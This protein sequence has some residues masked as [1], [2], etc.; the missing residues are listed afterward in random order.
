[1]V[2]ER[3]P[4]G[5]FRFPTDGKPTVS[6]VD[7][8]DLE[9][10]NVARPQTQTG[11]QEHDGPVAEAA[12]AITGSNRALDIFSNKVPWNRGKLPVGN[13]RKGVFASHR[14]LPRSHKEAEETADRDRIGLKPPDFVALR[15][16]QHE[17]A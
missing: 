17:G 14:A 3:K 1:L 6:P 13:G 15:P 9:I 2:C 5:T 7:I 16:F 4:L 10:R 8:G 11:K 12:F